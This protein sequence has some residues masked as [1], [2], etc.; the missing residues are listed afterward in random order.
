MNNLPSSI[1]LRSC[2]TPAIFG[3]IHNW[4]FA[5]G[6]DLESRDVKCA[7]LKRTTYATAQLLW[8]Q[9]D[10]M[11]CAYGE[12]SGDY[13]IICNFAPGTPF[14]LQ[15]DYYCGIIFDEDVT[16]EYNLTDVNDI[17]FLNTLGIKLDPYVDSMDR[18]KRFP[19]PSFLYSTREMGSENKL[20]YS[21]VDGDLR[22]YIGFE[23]NGTLRAISRMVTRYS[24][25][26]SLGK[27]DNDEPIYV[28]GSPGYLCE[29]RSTMFRALCYD[30]TDE[31]F[32]YRV[33]AIL[34]PV[35][36]FSLILYDLFSSV[37]NH[38]AY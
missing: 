25:S 14:I 10:K 16:G 24:L 9:T 12:I 7:Q 32:G 2:F 13:K 3:C 22:H 23:G 17:G 5:A 20:R 26:L 34:A 11:G 27:C 21:I 33:I 19:S 15:T 31:Y 30:Y 35:A 18:F 6:K 29:E 37:M 36:L 28:G 38:G 8:A 1:P 4:F